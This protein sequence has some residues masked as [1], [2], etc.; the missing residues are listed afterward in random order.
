[1]ARRL[2]RS[3]IGK[4]KRRNHRLERRNFRAAEGLRR[5]KTGGFHI[6]EALNSQNPTRRLH[7]EA[8][9]CMLSVGRKLKTEIP[10]HLASAR[11]GIRF[12]KGWESLNQATWRSLFD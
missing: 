2:A 7:S 6:A 4:E 3:V 5:G 8:L 12:L 11:Q 10:V 9:G 1:M